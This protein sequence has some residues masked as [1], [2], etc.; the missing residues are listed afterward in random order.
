MTAYL[1]TDAYDVHKLRSDLDEQL[2]ERERRDALPVKPPSAKALLYERAY[3]ALR[4]VL[5]AEQAR[6]VLYA[7]SREG[8]L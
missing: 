3:D 2:P 7:A 8:A 1:A 6:A 5:T 4:S